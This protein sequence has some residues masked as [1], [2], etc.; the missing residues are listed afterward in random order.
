VLLRVRLRTIVEYVEEHLDASPILE[1]TAAAACVSPYH[2]VQQFKRPLDCCPTSTT[3][4]LR[5]TGEAAPASRRRLLAGAGRRA[6]RLVG[7]SHFSY[8]FMRIVGVMSW[9]FQ[10]PARTA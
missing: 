2:I 3:R 1:Q 8:H 7:Q 6:C 10:M 5:R 4:A 9:Q